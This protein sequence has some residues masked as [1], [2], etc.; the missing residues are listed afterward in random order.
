MAPTPPR[1]PQCPYTVLVP[2][3]L[4]SLLAPNTPPDAPKWS[5]HPLGAPNAPIPLL[6][7]EYLESLLAPNAPWTPPDALQMALHL[8]GAPMLLMPPIP[9]LMPQYLESLLVQKGHCSNLLK[10]QIF[11]LR[12]NLSSSLPP[13]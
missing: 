13:S 4:E 7:P 11:S 1:S 12:V 9:L 5:L 6:V 3:Y 2:E 8:L 10:F